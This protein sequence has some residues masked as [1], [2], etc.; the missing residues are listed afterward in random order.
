MQVI[1]LGKFKDRASDRNLE[2]VAVSS[3]QRGLQA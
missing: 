1:R 3:Y 2:T